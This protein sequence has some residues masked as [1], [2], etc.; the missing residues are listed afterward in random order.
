[1]K[2][3]HDD[4]LSVVKTVLRN[5]F[6]IARQKQKSRR[7]TMGYWCGEGARLVGKTADIRLHF[8]APDGQDYPSLTGLNQ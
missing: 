6:S 5:V 7:F 8:T 2:L 4:L 3:R 1:M